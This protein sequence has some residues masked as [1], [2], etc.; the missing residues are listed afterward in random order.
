[1]IVIANKGG[2]ISRFLA[3]RWIS[4]GWARV[5]AFL[6]G[7]ALGAFVGG[8][9]EVSVA[10]CAVGGAFLGEIILDTW[11]RRRRRRIEVRQ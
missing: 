8:A 11:W 7:A 1:M 10:W 6:V 3:A 2:G 5:A 4:P 9:V